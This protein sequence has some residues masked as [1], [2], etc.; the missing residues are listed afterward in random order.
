MYFGSMAELIADRGHDVT[1]L[2]G[3]NIRLPDDVMLLKMEVV[4]Y[5]D[6]DPP[7]AEQ[8]LFKKLMYDMA[9]KPSIFTQMKVLELAN[10]VNRNPPRHLLEDKS[11]ME[12]LETQKFDM[13]IIDAM[14]PLYQFV[15]YK[16]GIPYTL[17]TT[18]CSNHRRSIPIMPSYVPGFI[19]SFTDKM[20]FSQ[21]L[22]NT[23][24]EFVLTIYPMGGEDV[25]RKHVHELPV[26]SADELYKNAS[27]CFQLRDGAL[28]FVQPTMP[29][30][31]LV[32]SI[33]AR[34]AVPLSKDLQSFMDRS[35][36]GVIL[37]S[38]DS[39]LSDLPKDIQKKLME[40][41]RLLPHDVIMKSKKSIPGAPRNVR[42]MSFIPQNDLLAHRNLKLFITHCGINSLIEAAYHAVPVL[43]FP[44]DIDQHNNAALVR[45]RGIGESLLLS[46]FTTEQL[47]DGIVRILSNPKYRKNVKKLSDILKDGIEN[48]P[49]D[50]VFWLEHVIKYGA[51]HLRAHAY[52]MPGYQYFMFDVLAILS[53][54]TLLMIVMMCFV[55][56]CIM[57]CICRK[58][59]TKSKE[60]WI[61]RHGFDS[62]QHG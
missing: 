26:T 54:V 48:G 5:L 37:M 44:F 3:S 36:L 21:R 24:L 59:T 53:G 40:T 17:L 7:V 22:V 18:T 45:A 2:A 19:T 42:F 49:N 56:R 16:L 13:A 6:P 47:T 32:G 14:M 11:I 34:P 10:T 62:S 46:N 38:L 27:L 9:F 30:Q 15:P 43:G 1:F 39:V 51:K 31:I 12:W 33:M 8:P 60:E 52:E 61:D 4:K 25:S 23:L 28:S 50:P 41:F 20:T 58:K 35:K 57:G 55:V 29:D